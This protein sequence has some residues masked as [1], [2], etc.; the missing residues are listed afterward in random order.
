VTA[1]SGLFDVT[2]YLTAMQARETAIKDYQDTLNSSGLSD[3][4][5]GFLSEQ[6]IESAALML[7]GYKT[8]APGQRAELDRIWT[9]SSKTSSGAFVEGVDKTLSIYK[10]KPVPVPLEVDDKALTGY[11]PKPIRVTVDLFTR[12]GVR[13]P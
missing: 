9:E 8:A 3:E 5:K 13:I 7:A 2:A 11:V 10:P 1:E 4:A 6:G 12:A